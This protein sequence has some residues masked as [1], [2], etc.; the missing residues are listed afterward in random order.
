MIQLIRNTAENNNTPLFVADMMAGVG[1][2]AIPLAKVRRDHEPQRKKLKVHGNESCSNAPKS[3]A[4]SIVVYA[5]GK[6]QY[7]QIIFIVIC[8]SD[9]NPASYKYLTENM[10]LNHIMERSTL[11]SYNKDAR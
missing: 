5:N 3:N 10:E 11:F 1:P 7:F 8:K 9:L 2:F 4:S 6:V